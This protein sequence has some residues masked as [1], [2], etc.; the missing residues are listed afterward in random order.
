LDEGVTDTVTGSNGFTAI[1]ITFESA[2]L[3]AGHPLFDVMIQ[4][5]E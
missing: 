3:T 1:E 4:C 5:K 2:L